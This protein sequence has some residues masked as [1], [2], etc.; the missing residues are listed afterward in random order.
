MVEGGEK[1]PELGARVFSDIA[2]FLYIGYIVFS[3]KIKE[4]T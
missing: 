1:R 4:R 2:P 3:K